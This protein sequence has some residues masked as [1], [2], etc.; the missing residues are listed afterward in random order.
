MSI[1]QNL[2]I[3]NKPIA[4]LAMLPQ[5]AIIK[6]AQSGQI[7]V[8]FVAPI[9]GEKA[10][11]TK[12]G[13]AAAAM[14]AQQQMPQP[15]VLEKIM[16]ENAVGEVQSQLPED[17]G[18]GALPVDEGMVPEYAGGG[19]VAFQSGGREIDY[20][21]FGNVG[22]ELKRQEALYRMYVG[23]N[24]ALKAERE[25]MD[26]AAKEKQALRLIE[27]GLGIMGGESPYAAVNIGKGSQAALKGYGEDIAAQRKRK[28]E[29]AGVERAERGKI[30]ASALGETQAKEKLVP[31]TIR[32]AREIQAEA[33][34]AGR[35]VPTLAEAIK[36]IERT[37]SDTT[38]RSAFINAQAKRAEARNQALE[39]LRLTTEYNKAR[40]KGDTETMQRLE[41]E[42]RARVDAQY[43]DF[44]PP[45][46]SD[47][48]PTSAPPDLPKGAKQIGTSGGKPVY[49]LPDGRRVIQ[50]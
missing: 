9:L 33:K 50:S 32:A 44:L 36:S 27:A 34:A 24:E 5:E 30:L 23:E 1:L 19:I 31:E 14:I 25:G 46:T 18:I 40:R 13:A 38:L 17:V 43:A 29:L 47:A 28:A 12:A 49:E 11:Q 2:K 3:L 7:P 45:G 22:E 35:K 37:P 26:A 42:T 4:E 39:D 16:A 41:R 48:T 8:G 15:T 20:S 10:E 21:K 6:L